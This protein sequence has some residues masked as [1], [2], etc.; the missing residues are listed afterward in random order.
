M[1]VADKYRCTG[2]YFLVFCELV[3]AAR[4]RGTVT[5]QE[6][7]D[8]VG[9]PTVGAHM[10]KEVGH[11]CGEISEDEHKLGRP[12]LSAVVVGVD[13]TPGD[14]FFKLAEDLGKL[15]GGDD[16]VRFWREE[17]SAVYKLWQRRF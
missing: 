2:E 4:H 12:M 15:A 16:R 7:A 14:G 6:V 13:G 3:K 8:V 9:M 10:G 1:V 17:Q 11:L 5:Y